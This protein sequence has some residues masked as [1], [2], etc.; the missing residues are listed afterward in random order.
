MFLNSIL[1]LINR[2]KVWGKYYSIEDKDSAETLIA[3]K[4]AI[5]WNKENIESK[6]VDSFQKQLDS[7]LSR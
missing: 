3:Y 2:R 4:A 6:Y 7:Y 5:A 1:N